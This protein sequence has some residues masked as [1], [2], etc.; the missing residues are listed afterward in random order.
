VQSCIERDCELRQAIRGQRL[1][2]GV[3]R[4]ETVVIQAASDD[5]GDTAQGQSFYSFSCSRRRGTDVPQRFEQ[6]S[7]NL[8]KV[9]TM[10]TFPTEL[11]MRPYM[12]DA[13]NGYVLLLPPTRSR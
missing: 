6:N 12:H 10:V 7:S 1:I 2:Y 5:V 8:S 3:E 4:D 11:D 13:I 9:E